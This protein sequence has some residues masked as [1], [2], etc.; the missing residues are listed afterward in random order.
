M[1]ADSER[2]AEIG[3]AVIEHL[4]HGDTAAL[5]GATPE[6]VVGLLARRDERLRS[7]ETC[8]ALRIGRLVIALRDSLGGR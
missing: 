2:W 8:D 7:L 5:Q 1:S 4:H 3:R 6:R